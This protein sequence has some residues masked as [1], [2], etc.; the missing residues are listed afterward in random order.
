MVLFVV[1]A[2]HYTNVILRNKL[3]CPRYMLFSGRSLR[4]RLRDFKYI[5]ENII[6]FFGYITYVG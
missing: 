5:F 1:T 2:G 6:F 3:Y 4:K